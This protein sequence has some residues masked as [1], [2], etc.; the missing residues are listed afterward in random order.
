MTELSSVVSKPR[1]TA[2]DSMCLGLAAFVAINVLM[3]LW[4]AV[5]SMSTARRQAS[6][7]FF[8]LENASAISFNLTL[9]TTASATERLNVTGSLRPRLSECS[10]RLHF[11][12]RM[13]V[14]T[15][16]E[17]ELFVLRNHRGYRR[18]LS[19]SNASAT[20]L[21]TRDIPPLH[22]LKDTVH[23]AFRPELY[24]EFDVH[25]KPLQ[26]TFFDTPFVPTDPVLVIHGKRSALELTVLSDSAESPVEP[27]GQL[28]QC[29]YLQAPMT[30]GEVC[31]IQ[32]RR[33]FGPHIDACKKRED[34]CGVQRDD[35]VNKC[36]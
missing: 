27:F 20:C 25:C 8:A 14:T 11:D 13:V 1:W 19:T 12:G 17:S 26:F 3:C 10:H 22:A 33:C 18:S 15:A 5:T 24:S 36:K 21:T 6:A 9:Q 32:P 16:N 30:S 29:E 34:S 7:V 28:E 2:R 4:V 35:K 23:S 31:S